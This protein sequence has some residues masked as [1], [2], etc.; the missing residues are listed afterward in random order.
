MKKFN[1]L[2]AGLV[3]VLVAACL[4]QD[5]RAGDISD[6]VIAVKEF[7][8]SGGSVFKDQVKSSL[9]SLETAVEAVIDALDTGSINTNLNG[10]VQATAGVLT[11][12][13]LPV[14]SGGTGA[15]TLTGIVKGT[16]TTA[17]IPAVAGTDY[18]APN[19]V[20]A[21]NVIVSGD[22]K[23][24]TIIVLKGLITSWVVTE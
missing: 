21:T 9:D 12:G 16:G 5:M 17:M 15:A 20:N 6:P 24:N 2:L 14:A 7:T 3:V 1:Y 19:A 4:V 23:T 18:L 22:S 13:T 8:P 11:A 10:A